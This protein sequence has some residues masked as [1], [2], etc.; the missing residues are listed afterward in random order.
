V[1]NKRDKKVLR[2]IIDQN[3]LLDLLIEIEISPKVA[4]NEKIREPIT[5]AREK[6]VADLETVRKIGEVWKDNGP[7]KPE[8]EE[9]PCPA[10]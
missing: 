9:P 8:S 3:H 5:E 6:L 1:I 4:M 10:T 2:R 7:A